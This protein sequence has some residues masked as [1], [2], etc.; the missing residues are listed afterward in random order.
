MPKFVKDIIIKTTH[1]EEKD[2]EILQ[3]GKDKKG[4]KINADIKIEK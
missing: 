1:I 2:K 4:I 3:D